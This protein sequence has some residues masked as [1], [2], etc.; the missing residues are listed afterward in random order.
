MP[1]MKVHE[2]KTWPEYFKAIKK[3]EK[4]FELRKNDRDFEKGD[5]LVLREFI[6]CKICGGRGRAM[7]GGPDFDSC[8]E[9]PHGEYTGRKIK[10]KVTYILECSFH[11][12]ENYVIMAIKPV[13]KKGLKHG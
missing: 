3:G 11:R 1:K 10:R 4:T 13:K 6:P 8:C 9:K 5:I 7:F 2:L 12:Y